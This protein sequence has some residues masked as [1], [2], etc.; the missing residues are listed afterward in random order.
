MD[1]VLICD[2]ENFTED[3]LLSL[4]EKYSG[5]HLHQEDIDKQGLSFFPANEFFKLLNNGEFDPT[6]YWCINTSIWA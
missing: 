5:N 6:N 1:I 3:E 2:P 4:T